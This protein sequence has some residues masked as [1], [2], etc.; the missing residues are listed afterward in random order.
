MT[1]LRPALRWRTLWV[2]LGCSMALAKS[3][4][5]M[6]T[7]TSCSTTLSSSSHAGSATCT[8]LVTASTPSTHLSSTVAAA[9]AVTAS[10]SAR[11]SPGASLPA[12]T[13]AQGDS[14]GQARVA[15]R[16]SIHWLESNT[17]IVRL[18]KSSQ[19]RLSPMST[20]KSLRPAASTS[21]DH[22][23]S[24]SL[25]SSTSSL[26][27][28]VLADTA[29]SSRLFPAEM[30]S[31]ERSASTSGTSGM[32]PS[33]MSL[34]LSR[35]SSAFGGVADFGGSSGLSPPPF[36]A[37]EVGRGGEPRLVRRGRGEAWVRGEGRGEPR[38]RRSRDLE[39]V[40]RRRGGEQREEER[41]EREWGERGGETE[42][43]PG[44]LPPLLCRLVLSP[45][46]RD[47]LPPSSLDLL[48]PSSLS[49][50]PHP[51]FTTGS[52]DTDL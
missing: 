10:A 19:L 7:S 11:P 41:W 6:A 16:P 21:S 42:L 1:S 38:L 28:E 13:R 5:T 8:T 20:S 24:S 43:R 27:T 44:H 39:R 23:A 37:L 52:R 31:V 40:A 32:S 36:L 18:S 48:P 12:R 2:G 29:S 3:I 33:E 14:V 47:L 35:M 9:S 50:L 51:S 25:I 22:S 34:T 46:S 49:L 4:P 26:T 45:S 17:D 15:R 30:S